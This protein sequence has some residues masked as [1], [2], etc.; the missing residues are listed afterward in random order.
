M[1]QIPIPGIHLLFFRGDTIQFQ[2][3]LNTPAKGK[4]FIRTNIGNARRHRQEIIMK[5]ED[6]QPMA[7]LDWN[8]IPMKAVDELTFEV[9]LG[10]AEVGHFEAKCFFFLPDS[11]EPQWC[12]GDN[13]HINV[14]P[15]SYCAGNSIYCAF[16]RQFGNNKTKE[17][18]D[19]YDE[20]I[21]KIPTLDQKGYAVIPPSGTLRDLKKEVSFI[22]DTLRCRILH[23]LPV[24]PVPTTFARMGRYGSPYASLDYTAIDPALAEF[25][26]TATPL[27]Q[28]FELIDEVHLKNGKVILDLAINHTGWAAKIHETHPEWLKRDEHGN[29]VS[30]GAWGVTWGDLT[31]LD[32]SHKELWRYFADVFATWCERGIDGFRCDAGYMIPM[33]IWEYIIASVKQQY[34][35]TIFLLEGLGGDPNITKELL[36]RANMNWAY[37]E[38]FQNYSSNE[39][40]SYLPYAQ[41]ISLTDGLMV[42]Y[43][44]THD[45]TRLA[46]ISPVYS[47]LRTALS[48]FTSPA[49]A[50]AFANGVE[51]F[52]T[53]KID[54]HE[55]SGLNWG[56]KTNQVDFIA[57]LNN[58]LA[59]HPS[60][61]RRGKLEFI[62]ANA[63]A[64]KFDRDILAFIRYDENKKHF[65]LFL[66]NLN[67]EQS[68]RICFKTPE[69]LKKSD[70][71]MQHP[72]SNTHTTTQYINLINEK[73]YKLEIY[74]IENK[75]YSLLLEPG[76]VLCLTPE[77]SAVKALRLAENTKNYISEA[78]VI[79]QAKAM[80]MDLLTIFGKSAIIT[81][82][83][84][85]LKYAE[86]LLDKPEESFA[87]FFSKD[88]EIPLLF[89]ESP[90]DITR[91]VM[92]PP[93]HAIFV[94]APN[95]FRIAIVDKG[96]III[97]R[98]SLQDASGRDFVI[99]PPIHPKTELEF[100][101]IKLSQFGV[102]GLRR[103]SAKL[104]LLPEQS[105]P[106]NLKLNNQQIR[107]ANPIYMATNGC[108]GM[109]HIP[110]QCCE[111]KSKYDA[112]LAANL[113]TEYPVDR[114]IM[115]NSMQ[116]FVKYQT[117]MQQLGID[118]LKSFDILPEKQGC[119]VFHVPI[120]NG[121]F[122][123]IRIT[124]SMVANY[125]SSLMQIERL[126]SSNS[127]DAILDKNQVITIIARANLENRSFH[128]NT[129]INNETRD[130]WINATKAYNS[131]FE[132]TPSAD[133]KL[134]L[135]S[136]IV[137]SNSGISLD[138]Q[139][140]LDK[141]VFKIKPKIYY[142]LYN[143]QE[144]ERGLEAHN[145][146]FS[147]GYFK[148][149]LKASE[150]AV[151]YGETLSTN[152]IPSNHKLKYSE[153]SNSID[154]NFETLLQN[155]IQ[156]FIVKRNDLKTV[157]AGYPWFLDWGRDTLICARGMISAGY[158]KEVEDIIIAF[159]DFAENGTLPN[160]IHG[161]NAS[162]RDTSD[163]PLWLFTACADL[164]KKL[165]ELDLMSKV[166]PNKKMSII[167][168]LIEIAEAYI[169]GTP[170]G[171]KMDK[172]SGL[173][174]SPPHFTWMDTNYPAGTPRE[175]YPIEIQALWF[176]ALNFLYKQTEQE[177]WKK[178]SQQ[179][180]VSINKL[181]IRPEGW[182]ADCLLAGKNIPAANA[183]KDDAL[184][185]NQLLAI[186]LNAVDDI[187]IRRAILKAT[188]FLLIPGAIRSLA[189]RQ[190]EVPIPVYGT[191]GQ[192]LND[193]H[194]PY[195]GYYE[196]D[197]DTRRKP[198]YH[199]GTAWT[200]L[201][202]SYSEAYFLTYS[203]S[204]RNTALSI[205][206]S[207]Q[208]LIRKGC[209][210][211]IPEIL[212]GNQPH[213]QRGCDAQAWG[214]TE[215]LRV[216]SIINV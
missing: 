11:Q 207:S 213:L 77:M 128:Q 116:I 153:I 99:L 138:N 49:G 161:A 9:T 57:K 87:S 182:L 211:H 51:W 54:V 181:F 56:N 105:T 72:N 189:N 175:G 201:F 151:I 215:L 91:H 39:I 48:A 133:R 78:I 25:D 109:M 152:D 22:M 178:L 35:D 141:A 61:H 149:K 68:T 134:I 6:H 85:I 169:N 121:R 106:F 158:T 114:W 59:T 199:N 173:I 83:H 179:V 101:E 64:S 119:W 147:P 55:A 47:K 120:G 137:K 126:D 176:A 52:A 168:I 98:D 37:S 81:E 3:Q 125:N 14:E 165:P 156:D 28:M 145:D 23:L 122:I 210:G 75:T 193:P 19:K 12:D 38:L 33:H 148:F 74:D 10:L 93:G 20:F 97:Q 188:S 157:I 43:A 214:I 95:R 124:L 140:N 1:K 110:V 206:L 170:N 41:D 167:D 90:A 129:K 13:V 88:T 31:E 42:N 115:W 159:A 24:N 200:W 195:W 117:H 89:W 103:E 60:F 16:P 174:Y 5:T 205:L 144:A 34:P 185:P 123:D 69:G 21:H 7:G 172:D 162:N 92:L 191:Q 79:Q 27:E 50:F 26:K 136:Q 143:Q 166:T 73:L 139:S 70:I 187:K 164:C 113:N 190:V 202:P 131:S 96:A 130:A 102:N 204:G 76:E 65:L 17:I 171:I 44:E 84:D 100:L 209:I 194:H 2:L 186:T 30:P 40:R 184:R 155:N 18:S 58:I 4:A 150:A 180:R 135:K 63:T 146:M 29:I 45:N 108:G 142:N 163:A 71:V 104:I 118:C 67:C 15:A 62:D 216:Y 111:F 198:A 112:F 177:K 107:S 183:K 94:S 82:E 203:E 32:H 127:E 197:E 154:K 212:D 86:M 132:F 53:E 208:L 66:C 8:D 160:I 46:A 192:L 80:V 36:N 196:G